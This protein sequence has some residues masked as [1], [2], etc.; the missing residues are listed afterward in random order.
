MEAAAATEEEGGMAAVF[1]AAFMAA[2]FMA[3]FVA[4]FGGAAGGG[5]AAGAGAIL[6][7]AI[8]ILIGVTEAAMVEAITEAVMEA[9][10]T[11]A[12]MVVGA[13]TGGAVTANSRSV[14][15]PKNLC[16]ARGLERGVQNSRPFLVR[17]LIRLSTY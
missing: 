11:G 6:T 2:V 4:A 9:A 5:G 14:R 17:F 16:S 7:G 10:I 13:I 12:V 1:M 15:L 3:G 8:L